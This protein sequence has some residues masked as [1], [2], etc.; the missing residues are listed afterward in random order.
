VRVAVAGDAKA[1]LGALVALARAAVGEACGVRPELV[2]LGGGGGAAAAALWAN[3]RL[4]RLAEP[5]GPVAWATR[6]EAM[7]VLAHIAVRM[8]RILPFRGIIDMERA[9]GII[10]MERAK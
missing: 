10:D 7:A 2:R 9:K 3:P 4:L 1:V 8:A 5:G 6:D